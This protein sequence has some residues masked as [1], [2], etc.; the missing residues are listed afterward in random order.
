GGPTPTM[1][2]LVGSPARDTNPSGFPPTDQRGV[3][4]PQ[5]P[6]ADIGAFEA[7]FI[8]A[9][10][11]I[12]TQPQGVT[13]RARTNVTFTVG[14][15][16]SWPLFYQWNKDNTH[17]IPGATANSLVLSNVHAPDQG[18]YSVVVT[19]IYG[20]AASTGAVLVVDWTPQL[21]LSHSAN[22]LT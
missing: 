13:V 18:T 11:S 21:V 1:G 9:A 14:A 22:T 2:L 17:P 20:S 8:S 3:S 12:V 7:S 6:A 15:S 5:G 16:G 4:R 19:N 10:P